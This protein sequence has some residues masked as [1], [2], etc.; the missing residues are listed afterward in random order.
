MQLQKIENDNDYKYLAREGQLVRDGNKVKFK[1][2]TELEQLGIPTHPPIYTHQIEKNKDAHGCYVEWISPYRDRNTGLIPKGMYRIWH[3]PYAQ[4]KAKD[5]ITIKDSLGCAYVY[6]RVNNLTSGQGDILVASWIGR[7]ERM[8]EYNEQ[9]LRLAEYWNAEVMFES[10]R[11]DVKGYFARKKR[12]DL[13][14]DE[15]DLEWE[16]AIKKARVKSKGMVMNDARKGKGAIYLRDWLTQKRGTTNFGEEK[17]NL[18]Y[19]YDAGL[20]KELLKWNLKGNFDRVSSLIV[21]MYDMHECFNKEIRPEQPINKN[22]FF[23]RPLF[24]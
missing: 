21:G 18:E 1:H 16:N 24:T 8:D 11:G 19:I 14:A 13:L 10:N 15:P 3:D 20:L 9:L 23:N 6:E 12:L 22:D 4:D 2:N 7:P 17:T 5:N